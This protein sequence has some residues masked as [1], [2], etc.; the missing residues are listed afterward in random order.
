ME[1]LEKCGCA[2]LLAFAQVYTDRLGCCTDYSPSPVSCEEARHGTLKGSQQGQHLH[3]VRDIVVSPYDASSLRYHC[4]N[5]KPLG[6]VP[7][8]AVSG[9][10]LGERP[11]AG[12]QPKKEQMGGT[13]A[14]AVV[15]CDSRVWRRRGMRKT[16][17]CWN[18][19]FDDR[20]VTWKARR[21]YRR[22]IAMFTSDVD[23]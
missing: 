12:Y 17:V 21:L 14:A 6:R 15:N 23:D 8:A 7:A 19:S 10:C 16:D 1:Q 18:D 9:A 5:H 2:S 20:A 22:S 11:R 4:R 3:P 13:S